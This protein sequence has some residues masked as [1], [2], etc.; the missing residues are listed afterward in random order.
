MGKKLLIIMDS[1][2]GGGA[3][4]ALAV[5]LRHLDANKIH[6]TLLLFNATGPRMGDIPAHVKTL[7][8]YH[9]GKPLRDRLAFHTPLRDRLMARQL[10]RLL[11]GERFDVALSFLEGAAAWLHSLL[12]HDVASRHLSWV[13]TDLTRNHW[14]RVF[15]KQE[16][17][18]HAFYSRLDGLIFASGD[19]MRAFPFEVE[20]PKHV[21]HNIIDRDEVRQ[22][23]TALEFPKCGFTLCYVGR[24]HSVKRPDRFIDTVA[25]LRDEG[26]DVQAW[27]VGDGDERQRLEHQCRDKGLNDRVT[28]W[29]FQQNPYPFIAQANALVIASDAEGF[30]L[31]MLEALTLG[32]PVVATRCAGPTEVLSHGGGLL[33]DFTPEALATAIK[34][35]HDN[36]DIISHPD[37]PAAF[38]TSHIIAQITNLLNP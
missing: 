38:T 22:L 7:A 21:V 14:S 11:G 15:F 30:S 20:T 24:L 4:K 31:V 37:L 17:N 2:A 12:P 16:E 32:T 27:L 36:P 33:T 6:I 3:E 9:G 10:R 5:L 26:I 18:E 34:E 25:L 1:M 28:F 35:L 29:G 13:H 8:V 23:A 19:A